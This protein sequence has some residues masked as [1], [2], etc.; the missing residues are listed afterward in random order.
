MR[1]FKGSHAFIVATHID[2]KH[3]HNHIIIN[4]T[5]LECTGKF[6]DFKRSGNVVRR[7]SDLICIEPGLSIIENP[8][9]SKGRNYGK[10]LAANG[11][12]KPPTNAETLK[13]KIDEIVPSCSTFA[14]F[15]TK[16]KAD[17]YE[18]FENRKNISVR[19]SDWGQ[20][21]RLNSL[22]GE[23][24]EAA[25]RAR[26]DTVRI[27]SAGGDSGTKTRT[28]QP[29]KRVSLLIDIQSKLQQGK[30]KGYEQWAKLHN[31]KEAAKTLLYLQENGI[32]SYEELVKKSSSTSD[33]FTTL[34]TKI[35]DIEARLKTIAETQK[36]IGTY[37][38]T[39][40]V[41]ARY[42]A[43]KWNRDFYEEHRAEITLHRAAKKY[44][45]AQNFKGKLP[46]ISSLKQE[47]ATLA[48]EKK[49]LYGDYHKLKDSSRELAVARDN[50]ERILGIKDAKNRDN[51]R[52]NNKRNSREK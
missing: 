32:D 28:E 5:N 25:I 45:D 43:S 33:D 37:G 13:Q 36:H 51:S 34:T 42:K 1:F 17:G 49:K 24:T 41:Y 9:P 23:Y 31:L 12:E 52:D 19:A 46:S 18:V 26:L 14:D 29:P 22:K 11:Y 2:K 20:N 30:G 27:I 16:L 10:W 39:R 7:I 48:A 40:E 8:K 3:T 35:K 47:Y 15:I 21:I 50:T 38:K 6:M 4:S 44:F